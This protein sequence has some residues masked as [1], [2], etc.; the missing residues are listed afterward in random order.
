MLLAKGRGHE[1]LH[2]LS[3]QRRFSVAE[4]ALGGR[5]E[6]LNDALLADHDRRIGHGV[7]NRPQMRLT[8][9]EIASGRLIMDAGAVELL[10]EPGDADADAGKDRDFYDLGHRQIVEAP[11]ENAG[12][13]TESGRDQAGPQSTDAGGKQDRRDE[14]KERPVPMEKGVKPEP[15]QKRGSDG[16]DRE[17]ILRRSGARRGDRSCQSRQLAGLRK[18]THSKHLARRDCVMFETENSFRLV[19]LVK[20]GEDM[21][22]NDAEMRATRPLGND[23]Q[24]IAG[25]I[26]LLRE[27]LKDLTGDVKRLGAHQVENVQA[28]AEAALDDLACAVQRNPLSAIGIAFGAGLLYGVLTRR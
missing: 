16:H 9:A 28:L 27:D 18:Q 25:D 8:G 14:Q 5:V 7:E 6:G 11:D 2:I 20:G 24:Q 3:N 15:E 1:H 19:A 22:P 26:N 21:A 4:Q 10:A 23:L 17:P 13:E 12:D